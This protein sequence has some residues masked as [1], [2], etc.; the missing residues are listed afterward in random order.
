MMD[1]EPRTH[2]GKKVVIW[3]GVVVVVGVSVLVLLLFLVDDGNVERVGMPGPG[4]PAAV[5]AAT[6]DPT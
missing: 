5:T 1:D 3:L 2:D 4:A 6:L